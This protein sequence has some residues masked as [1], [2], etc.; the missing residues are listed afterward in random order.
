M[1]GLDKIDFHILRLLQE[2]SNITNLSLSNQIGLS[3]APTLERV[4]KLE[5][6]GTIR[7]YHADVDPQALGLNVVTFILVNITWHKQNAADNFLRQVNEIDEITECYTI[8]GDGDFLLKVIC[9]DLQ[10]YQNL[11]FNVLSQVPE[12]E[13]LK[14]LMTLSTVKNRKVLPFNYDKEG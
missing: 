3:P 10:A 12:V 13:R 6:S 4:K 11:L 1:E 8:T 14:T 7:S 2:N 5:K 9:R